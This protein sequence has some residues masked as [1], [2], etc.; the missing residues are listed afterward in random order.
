MRF[1]IFKNVFLVSVFEPADQGRED[2]PELLPP[3]GVE[4]NRQCALCL[5]FGDDHAN[6]S[7]T[8]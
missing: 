6:V 1:L 4:D 3:P 7:S 5:K 2:S 8:Y